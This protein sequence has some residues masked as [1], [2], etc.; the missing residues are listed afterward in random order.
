MSAS[1]LSPPTD[2]KWDF[3]QKKQV[4][5]AKDIRETMRFL[6]IM[7]IPFDVLWH[8]YLR[9]FCIGPPRAL[10]TFGLYA[11]WTGVWYCASRSGDW[12]HEAIARDRD[13]VPTAP[14]PAYDGIW[15]RGTV[16][17][18]ASAKNLPLK[19]EKTHY[20]ACCSLTVVPVFA[21]LTYAY[22]PWFWQRRLPFKAVWFGMA[23]LTSRIA[24]GSSVA[25]SHS[26][27]KS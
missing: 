1:A 16:S 27:S 20:V 10:H 6:T 8:H 22:L 17:P 7:G 2:K 25:V 9:Q 21:R 5:S 26:R 4:P 14:L 18:V 15:D 23:Y 3:D 13:R 11:F 24:F 19:R 12:T